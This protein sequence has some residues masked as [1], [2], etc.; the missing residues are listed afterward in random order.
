MNANKLNKHG[1]PV[2]NSTQKKPTNKIEENYF[3]R[4]KGCKE[5]ASSEDIEG[6]C[7]HHLMEIDEGSLW[8]SRY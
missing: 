1:L 7:F 4:V 6:L 5:L 8:K 3:C 2:L